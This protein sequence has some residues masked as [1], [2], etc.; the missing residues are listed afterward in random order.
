MAMMLQ[1]LS[2]LPDSHT[3]TVAARTRKVPISGAPPIALRPDD[4]GYIGET[5]LDPLAGQ[6]ERATAAV[7]SKPKTRKVTEQAPQAPLVH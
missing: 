1:P 6:W 7:A 4:E 2:P 3:E 5:S